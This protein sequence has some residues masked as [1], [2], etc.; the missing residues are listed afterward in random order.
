MAKAEI[1]WKRVGPD[2]VRVQVYAQ[3]VGSRWIFYQRQ[4]RFDQWEAVENPPIEDWLELLDSVERRV[5]RLLLRPE[6][7]ARVRKTIH[8]RFPEAEF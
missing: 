8:E 3:H 7:A 1:S 6:E 5:A 4:R 2:G